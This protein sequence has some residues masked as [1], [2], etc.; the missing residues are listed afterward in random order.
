FTLKYVYI[1]PNEGCREVVVSRYE[2]PYQ[3]TSSKLL[4]TVVM[5]GIAVAMMVLSS[6]ITK[7]ERVRPGVSRGRGRRV[8][9]L[10]SSSWPG[11]PAEEA[12][13]VRVRPSSCVSVGCFSSA[14]DVVAVPEVFS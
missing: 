3:P 8:A 5:R 2:E 6:A 10:D 4:N 9:Y 13:V 1:L 11:S 14:A 7:V 12:D